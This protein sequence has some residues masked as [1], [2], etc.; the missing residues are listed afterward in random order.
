MPEYIVAQKLGISGNMVSRITGTIFVTRGSKQLASKSKMNVGLNLK[1][2]KENLQ[3][4]RTEMC[5]F[6]LNPYEP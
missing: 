2:N 4:I 5:W 6:L 1:I 3:V